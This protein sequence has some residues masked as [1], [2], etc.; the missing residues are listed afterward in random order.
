MNRHKSSQVVLL[1]NMQLLQAFIVGMLLGGIF[2]L[3]KL[4]MPAPVQ[5]GGIVGI[6]GVYT[7][8]VI[9]TYYEKS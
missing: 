5:F 6:L 1:T 7:G 2:T 3:L 9:V 8:Y 4:P